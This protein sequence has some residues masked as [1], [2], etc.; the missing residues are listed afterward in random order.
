MAIGRPTAWDDTVRIKTHAG[1]MSRTY[2]FRKTHHGPIVVKEDEQHRLSVRIGRMYE[3]LLLRQQTR[4]LRARNLVEFKQGLEL[5]NFPIMNVLY[6]DREGNIAYFY[7]GCIPRRDPQFDWS[8]P[9]DGSDP[10]T[11]WQGFHT[12][13]E[14]PQIENPVSGYV[15]ELQ[16]VPLHDHRRVLIRG[17]R[18]FRPTWLKTSTT[19]SGEPSARGKSSAICRGPRSRSCRSWPSTRPS[20]GPKPSCPFTPANM[21]DLKQSDPELA[22]QVA[23]YIE[24][25]LAWDCRST[26]EST[27]A[28]LCVAWYEELYGSDY[29]GEELRPAVCRTMCRSVSRP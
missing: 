22:R 12:L 2:H 8:K 26:L 7:N 28:T 4:L 6:A 16:L 20:I 9:V 23:P 5:L 21:P 13:G 1:V 19:T 3:S 11:E 10:R 27:A 15:A 29:P 25:L 24:H 17:S 14:L 18:I